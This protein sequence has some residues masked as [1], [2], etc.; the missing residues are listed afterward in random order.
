[1]VDA[2]RRHVP[3]E[4][5]TAVA[6][7]SPKF[8]PRW[9]QKP[10]ITH[11]TGNGSDGRGKAGSWVMHRRG[12]KDLT[13]MAIL[14]VLAW[15]R[16]GMYW[17]T[18]PTFEQGRKAIWEGFTADGDRIIDLMFPPEQVRSRDNQQ[19]KVELLNGSI[20][21]VIGTDKIEAV[22][23]GPV[24]VIHSEYS[25]AKPKAADLI[26]PMLR[27]NGGWELYVYTPR[28]NNHGRKL[29]DR[30][31]A[32][33]AREPAR[34]F[35]ELKTLYDTRAYD[36]DQTIAEERARGRPEAL[37]RQEYLCDWTAANVGA[38]WGDLIET[39]E[40][41]GAI[42]EFDF[43]RKRV[44]STWDLG[45][46]GAKGDATCFWLWAPTPDGADVLD[47]YENHGK[48]L[49]HYWDEMA[50]REAAIGVRAVRHWLPHDARA[51]HLTGVSVLE[52]SI[53]HWGAE[54][55]AIYPEDNLLNG[56]QA[57]RWLLQ[58]PVRFHPRCSEGIEALKA[59]HYEFDEDRN[60]L[61][62]Q[63]EHDWSS[64]AADGFRGLS[65]V[66]KRTE[67]MSRPEPPPEDLIA[68]ALKQPTLDE[69]FAYQPQPSGRI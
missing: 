40:K 32:A 31:K 20:Y 64:H 49:E 59:Y 61:S 48:T 55:V 42:A 6:I 33:A 23:A 29:H 25:I 4:A 62:N 39:L 36:P 15:R 24:G 10:V 69:L 67:A 14:D 13:A 22:G 12:G 30:M 66:V 16:L 58:R 37:I 19:M 43:D 9:Y 28:G 63:P 41:N 34:Y 46:S 50:R 60:T 51:K 27:E 7:P 18:F 44:F 38:V 35:C 17:H 3:R 52:Q 56:I 45:G 2:S 26:A 47:Y 11:F 68:K 65:L 1:M 53:K 8:K 54:R 5:M 21:R 57:G